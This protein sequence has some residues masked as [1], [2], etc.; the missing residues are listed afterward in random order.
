MGILFPKLNLV[1][2]FA[3][4]VLVNSIAK[5][6][7]KLNFAGKYGDFTYGTYV[8]RFRFSKC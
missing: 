2:F 1:F 5:I 6:K 7:G 4:P 8:F 3:L